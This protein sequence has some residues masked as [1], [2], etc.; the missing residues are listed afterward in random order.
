M[1]S[2]FSSTHAHTQRR[3]II[4]QFTS[5]NRV[6]GGVVFCQRSDP[7]ALKEDDERTRDS[8]PSTHHEV[9]VIGTEICSV[10][11]SLL[12]PCVTNDVNAYY[13]R[14]ARKG[15]FFTLYDL[16]AFRV[17]STF[18][19]WLLM[20]AADAWYCSRVRISSSLWSSCSPSRWGV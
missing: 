5:S 10:S 11:A 18:C 13:D 4:A 9:F 16:V 7:G 17:S 20:A 8:I 6:L 14:T 19:W 15:P 2:N 3:H 12:L 1:G